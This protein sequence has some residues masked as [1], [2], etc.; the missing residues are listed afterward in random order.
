M[1]QIIGKKI[2]NVDSGEEKSPFFRILLDDGTLIH[3]VANG[4]NDGSVFLAPYHVTDKEDAEI[5]ARCLP[6][7][8][9][10]NG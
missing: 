2:V 7:L 5:L 4:D 1:K 6:R 8:D 3:I 9:S 10:R